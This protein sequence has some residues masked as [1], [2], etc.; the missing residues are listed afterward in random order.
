MCP[1]HI[2]AGGKVPTIACKAANLR[3]MRF[4]C[5]AHIILHLKQKAAVKRIYGG[6]AKG[7]KKTPAFQRGRGGVNYRVN[8]ARAAAKSLQSANLSALDR[9]LAFWAAPFHAFH[10]RNVAGREVQ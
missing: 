5:A 8:A 7:I 3:R 1:P 6:A 9:A 10:A 2:R 4:L